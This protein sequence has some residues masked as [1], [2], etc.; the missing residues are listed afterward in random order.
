MST[1]DIGVH[2][3]QTLYDE[4]GTTPMERVRTYL[5]GA[6]DYVSHNLSVTTHT[7]YPRMYLSE[8][9]DSDYTY[10]QQRT[11][12][13]TAYHPCMDFEITYDGIGFY[14]FD[15][16]RCQGRFSYH[17]VHVLLT[18]DT[19]GIGHT[20]IF[21]TDDE[22]IEDPKDDDT[23]NASICVCEAGNVTQAPDTFT[24][25]TP[26]GGGSE[27]EGVGAIQTV[28]HELGHGLMHDTEGD[29]P[30]HN[31]GSVTKTGTDHYWTTPMGM[32]GDSGSI[33]GTWD[34][35]SY[36]VPGDRLYELVWSDCC[37]DRWDDQDL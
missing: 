14:F 19:R 30:D 13:A 34:L 29:H 10:E 26:T 4:Q 3:T 2:Q 7:E 9:S 33:C 8:R 32:N 16:L 17:D 31:V 20:P 11:R 37:V 27:A 15:K 36:S 21:D 35:S 22:P 24:R 25:Y 23:A 6:D 5:E 1:F 18:A 12:S 28:H